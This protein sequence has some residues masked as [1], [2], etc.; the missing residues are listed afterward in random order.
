M[1]LNNR[2]ASIGLYR[3]GF[4]PHSGQEVWPREK[5]SAEGTRY[6]PYSLYSAEMSKTYGVEEARQALPKLLDLANRGTS[7]IITRH[8]RPIAAL[9]PVDRAQGR[10]LVNMT[11]LR[12]SGKGL[13]T[14]PDSVAA[15]RD[16]WG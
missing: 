3:A 5:R 4:G 6:N 11:T 1:E 14:G 7:T 15:Q 16:E 12:G 8:G 9:V 13:W 2:S 10:A